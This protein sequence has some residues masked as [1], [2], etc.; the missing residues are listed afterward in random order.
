MNKLPAV[1][2]GV[3]AKLC[4][5]K[6]KEMARGTTLFPHTTNGGLFYGKTIAIVDNK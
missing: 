2:F 6:G 1:T 5:S 4:G 3:L